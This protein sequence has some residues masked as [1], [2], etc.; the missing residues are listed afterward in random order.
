MSRNEIAI[1][2]NYEK[3]VD[4][5]TSKFGKKPKS[6]FQYLRWLAECNCG[7]TFQ[8]NETSV[9]IELFEN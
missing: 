9:A 8:P 5:Y 7:H 2:T 4:L 1:R 3:Y 6:W